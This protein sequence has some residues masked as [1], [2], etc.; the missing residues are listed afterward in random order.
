MATKYSTIIS[1]FTPF[2]FAPSC[3]NAPCQFTTLLH[4]RSLI[5]ALRPFARYVLLRWPLISDKNNIFSDTFLFTPIFSGTQLGL[6]T[7]VGCIKNS[8]SAGWYFI[9]VRRVKQTY[10]SSRLHIRYVTL[11]WNLT[12][13]VQV[14]ATA[15]YDSSQNGLHSYNIVVVGSR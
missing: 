1:C 15:D 11:E 3:F 12:F 10:Y 7:R 2:C 4:L 13:S 8:L 6:K 14:F 9:W 5:F